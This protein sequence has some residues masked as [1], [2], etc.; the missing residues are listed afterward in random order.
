MPQVKR[1]TL[2]AGPGVREEQLHPASGLRSNFVT[3]FTTLFT[4]QA[5]V[6][7]LAVVESTSLED[8]NQTALTIYN[9]RMPIPATPCITVTF[10][11]GVNT[12][13]SFK[14]KVWGYNQFGEMIT[15]ETPLILPAQLLVPASVRVWLS[16]VFATITRVRYQLTFGTAVTGAFIG[17]GP[18]FIWDPNETP[19]TTG[20]GAV[21]NELWFAQA[22][23]GIGLPMRCAAVGQNDPVL[24]P[25][26]AEVT[27]V[28]HTDPAPP[29]D[30]DNMAS[31]RPITDA[32]TT[33]GGFYFGNQGTDAKALI[34]AG[35]EGDHNK[36]RLVQD[37]T[38][39]IHSMTAAGTLRLHNNTAANKSADT[40]EYRIRANTS[41][42]TGRR[43][44]QSTTK[45]FGGS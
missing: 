21:T 29:V 22:N 34:V 30:A 31:L 42:G 2:G 45:T 38:R 23:A 27:V 26:V 13:T 17:V 10:N 6:R 35:W 9:A 43:T 14:V 44:W 24:Y 19:P 39:V 15:E 4:S 41:L 40:I 8:D 37:G 32:D 11:P 33:K 36:I 3:G 5:V 1:H 12:D 7:N 16:K 18:Y 28:N 20:G 25:D